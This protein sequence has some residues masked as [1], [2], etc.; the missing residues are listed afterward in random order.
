MDRPITNAQF[1]LGNGEITRI[2]RLYLLNRLIP[3]GNLAGFTR[4]RQLLILT[5]VH[6]CG[7]LLFRLVITH[8]DRLTRL[9]RRLRKNDFAA[10][11]PES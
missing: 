11:S 1:D 6:H 4:M 2:G 3:L 7:R 5:I 10:A 8:E 9:Y